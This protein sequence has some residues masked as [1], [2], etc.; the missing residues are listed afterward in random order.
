MAFYEVV[1]NFTI[2]GEVMQNVI[3]YDITGETSDDF[4]GYA[5]SIRA[6]FV[7]NILPVIVP[8]MSF[9]DVTFRLDVPGGVGFTV[10][11]TA[12]PIAGSAADD[13]YAGQLALIVRKIAQSSVRPNKGRMYIGGVSSYALEGSGRWALNASTLAQ[14]YMTGLLQL[15][16]GFGGIALMQIKASNPLA[17]NTVPYNPVQVMQALGIPGTQRRRRQGVGV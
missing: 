7:G 1:L 2:D 15:D 9:N 4:S 13:N 12:G 6:S 8:S 17:P 16:S 11:F 14:D 3:H 5:D 10:P